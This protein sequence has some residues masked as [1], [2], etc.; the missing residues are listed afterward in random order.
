MAANINIKIL[1]PLPNKR[2]IGRQI[3]GDALG[4]GGY[5]RVFFAL[6]QLANIAAIKVVERTS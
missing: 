6:N 1:T 5:R 4:T 3:L 2:I